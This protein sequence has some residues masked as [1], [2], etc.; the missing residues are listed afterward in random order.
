[1]DFG[2]L[3]IDIEP[4]T[5]HLAALKRSHQ[6]CLVNDCPS[7]RVDDHH[8]V[9]HLAKGHLVDDV[10]GGAVERQVEREDIA[11]PEQRVKGDVLCAAFQVCREACAVVVDGPHAERV[12]AL[13]EGS[14]NSAHAENPKRLALRV[15][16]KCNS[17]A[18]VAPP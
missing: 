6:G 9:L 5:A 11:V 8:P 13:L 1:M 3:L 10:A 17:L 14:A 16:A 7:R 12:A 4:G 2:L 18:P 15:V